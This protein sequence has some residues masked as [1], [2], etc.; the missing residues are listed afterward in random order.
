MLEIW[1]L[2]RSGHAAFAGRLNTFTQFLPPCLAAYTARSAAFN[3]CAACFN[4]DS[5][6]SVATPTLTVT[7]TPCFSHWIGLAAPLRPL[8]PPIAAP[9]NLPVPGKTSVRAAP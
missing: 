6:S 3:R 8:P 1:H 9:F 4:G 7:D 5:A 2:P